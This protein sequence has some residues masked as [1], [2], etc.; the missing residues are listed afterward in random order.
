[1]TS[2]EGALDS[3][4]DSSNCTIQCSLANVGGDWLEVDQV[5]VGAVAGP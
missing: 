4:V 1:M 5:G 3:E 2:E